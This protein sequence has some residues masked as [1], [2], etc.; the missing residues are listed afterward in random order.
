MKGQLYPLVK[1]LLEQHPVLRDSD[2]KLRIA[3]WHSQGLSKQ[4]GNVQAI[5][6]SDLISQ[7]YNSESIRRCRQKIQ[8]S[9]PELRSS[10]K[11]QAAKDQKAASGGNF[12]Y[13]E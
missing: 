5:L 9:H 11:V 10:E 3:V 13:Q 6:Y 7:A 12:I 1:R 2:T 8:E 4:I